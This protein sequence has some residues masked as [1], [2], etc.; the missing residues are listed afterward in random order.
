MR[1]DAVHTTGNMNPRN[2]A[3]LLDVVPQKQFHNVLRSGTFDVPQIAFPYSGSIGAF[4]YFVTWKVIYI[5]MRGSP[6]LGNC[7][8]K[9]LGPSVGHNNIHG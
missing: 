5:R 1:I 7:S 2:A 6:L 3:T 8:Q 9:R 4:H